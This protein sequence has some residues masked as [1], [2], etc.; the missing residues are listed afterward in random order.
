MNNQYE[1]VILN[2]RELKPEEIQCAI[3]EYVRV[4]H[5]YEIENKRLSKLL[6]ELMNESELPTTLKGSGFKA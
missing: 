6:D 5:D 3:N 2:C 4:K 1:D